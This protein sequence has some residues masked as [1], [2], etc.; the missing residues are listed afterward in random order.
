MGVGETNA[1]E[2]GCA[3]ST[4][5]TVSYRGV[6][7]ETR[8]RRVASVTFLQT[9]QWYLRRCSCPKGDYRSMLSD[10]DPRAAARS[11]AA[12]CSV[13]GRVVRT[14]CR[15]KHAP[16]TVRLLYTHTRIYLSIYYIC[17][18]IVTMTLNIVIQ[19][20]CTRGTF[21]IRFVYFE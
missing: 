3:T 6:A 15:V 1:S 4:R 12:G 17:I 16:V 8:R 11:A 14:V 19:V 18:L 5:L 7:T 2:F 21:T 20:G 9:Y 10:C 13:L